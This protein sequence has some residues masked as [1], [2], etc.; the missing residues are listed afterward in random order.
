MEPIS[1]CFIIILITPETNIQLDKYAAKNTP[2]IPKF[3]WIIQ[4]A[5][6]S[7]VGV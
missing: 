3:Q 1:L 2:L 7:I 6:A 5:K 4:K